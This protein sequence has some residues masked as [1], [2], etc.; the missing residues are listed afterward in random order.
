[1]NLI[2]QVAIVIGCLTFG[3]L[4]VYLTGLKLP[5][6]II[7]LLALWSMLQLKIV[8]VDNVQDIGSFLLKNMG[9]FFVPPCV[10]M[11]NYFDILSQSIVPILVATLISTVL[12]VFVTGFTH[13]L[14]RKKK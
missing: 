2:K 14:M 7:G 12:V 3:E 9:I 4:I 6:S 8:K 10:A 1:M 13:Q 5:A 11:L